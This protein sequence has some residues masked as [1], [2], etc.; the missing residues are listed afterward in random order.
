MTDELAAAANHAASCYRGADFDGRSL[1]DANQPLRA[2]ASYAPMFSISYSMQGEPSQK[3]ERIFPAAT[4]KYNQAL[5]SVWDITRQGIFDSGVP[6]AEEAKRL[7][8]AFCLIFDAFIAA[9]KAVGAR[10][11]QVLQVVQSHKAEAAC[12]APSS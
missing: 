4:E 12:E 8:D 7:R 3:P 10:G 9:A 1:S 2:L 5:D 6:C 11:E